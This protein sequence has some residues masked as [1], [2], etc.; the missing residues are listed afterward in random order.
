MLWMFN[1][2]VGFVISL[3]LCYISHYVINTRMVNRPQIYCTQVTDAVGAKLKLAP[4][5]HDDFAMVDPFF[6]TKKRAV[7]SFYER[8]T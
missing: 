1:L 2:I 7:G 5:Y 4:P 8:S 6:S 3:S